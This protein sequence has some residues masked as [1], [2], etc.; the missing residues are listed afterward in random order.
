[1]ASR[2]VEL[3]QTVRRSR[4]L[5]FSKAMSDFKVMFPSFDY[6]VI[7]MVLRA[8]NG[9]VDATVDQLLSMQAENNLPEDEGNLDPELNV[10]LPSYNDTGP[11]TFDP[12]PAYTPRVEEEPHFSYDS[13]FLDPHLSAFSHSVSSR[14]STPASLPARKNH[15][16][17]YNPPLLGTLPSDFLRLNFDDNHD[18]AGRTPPQSRGEIFS[19]QT[20]N[21]LYESSSCERRSYRRH[22][23]RGFSEGIYKLQ[24]FD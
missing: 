18:T 13:T 17:Q 9:L 6:E 7:E 12:P 10:R 14:N 2:T 3:P 23:L 1:M 19:N 4:Q 8:N 15:T 22:E 24:K 11:S 16:T 21:P 20:S 5:D